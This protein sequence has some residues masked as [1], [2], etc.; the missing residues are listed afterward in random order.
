MQKREKILIIKTGYSEFL[1]EEK[2]SRIVSYG[3][4]LRTTPLLHPYKDNHV[5]WV[6]DRKAFPL[7][8][9]NPFIDKL[10]GFDFI[11]SE[12]LKAERFD[13]VINLE[14]VPGIC[15]LA[16]QI[17]AWRRYGFR[18]DSETGKAK[19]YDNAFDVLAVSADPKTK[20]NNQRI[21]HELLFDMVGKEWKKEELILGYQPKSKEIYDIGL[22]TTVGSKWPTKVWSKENWDALEKM[23]KEEGFTV[24]RQD[25]EENKNKGIMEDLN[26]YMDWI[27]SCRIIVSSDTLGLHLGIALKKKVLGL[28]GPT[29]YKEVYFYGRGKA[30]VSEPIPD[31][32]PCFSSTCKKE[33]TC[34]ENISVTTVYNEVKILNEI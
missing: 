13:T 26:L 2:D 6:T 16:D 34:M 9:G 19:A 17:S 12:Q 33:K 21:F 24:N 22:N 14:K 3:D 30:I 5:T 20:K 1:E 4:I 18:F 10:L 8:E 29:P 7:L 31:C 32:M 11:T 15:A 27:N 28:F 23:L 25:S